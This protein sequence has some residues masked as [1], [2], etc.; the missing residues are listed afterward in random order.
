M[1]IVNQKA[2]WKFLRLLLLKSM[3]SILNPSTKI[4]KNHGISP[5]TI[6]LFSE[7]FSAVHLAAPLESRKEKIEI[8]FMI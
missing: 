6:S 7:L 3:D 2:L 1:W 8:F 5:F 4:R